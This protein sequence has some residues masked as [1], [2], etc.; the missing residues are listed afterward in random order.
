MSSVNITKYYINIKITIAIHGDVY[1]RT[2]QTPESEPCST[3]QH[4]FELHRPPTYR[5]FST[6]FDTVNVFSLMIF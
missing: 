3:T 5:H 2:N 1:G 6:E 4:T